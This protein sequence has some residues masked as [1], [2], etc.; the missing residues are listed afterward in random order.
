MSRWILAIVFFL[1]T[2]G[3]GPTRISGNEEAAGKQK[4]PGADLTNLSWMAGSWMERKAGV[5]TEEHWTAPKGKMMLGMGRTVREKGNPSFEF[6]RIQQTASGIRYFASPQGRPATEFPMVS[7]KEKTVV[8][9][10]S[11]IAFPRRITYWMEK[12]G[13]L[14]GRIEGEIKGEKRSREWKWEKVK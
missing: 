5:E 3:T 14:R 13:L 2:C 9:E 11:R 1:V 7:L 8:F 6:M 12:D 10:N 4:P